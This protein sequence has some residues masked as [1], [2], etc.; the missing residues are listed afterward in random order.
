MSPVEAVLMDFDDTLVETYE[1]VHRWMQDVARTVGI[2]IP[3]EEEIRK[4]WGKPYLDVI[5]SLWPDKIDFD[6]YMAQERKAP[7]EYVPASRGAK[8]VM[9]YLMYRVPMGIVTSRRRDEFFAHAERSGLDLKLFKWLLTCDD[10]EYHKPDPRVFDIIIR[11]IENYGIA[12]AG[13]VYV[14]DNGYDFLA[15][16]DAGLQFFGVTTGVTTREEFLALGLEEKNILSSMAELP[17]RLKL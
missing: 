8:E 5:G 7:Y 12:K 10:T 3:T 9:E 14:G 16:R 11:D 4:L 15:A 17:G 13:V 2:R 1:I 6:R